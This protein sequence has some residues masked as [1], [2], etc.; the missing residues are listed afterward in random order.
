MV[1]RFSLCLERRRARRAETKT[2][3]HICAPRSSLILLYKKCRL[4]IVK[5]GLLWKKEEV[6]MREGMKL[7]RDLAWKLPLTLCFALCIFFLGVAWAPLGFYVP[8]FSDRRKD[9]GKA[10]AF[11]GT[12]TALCTNVIGVLVCAILVFALMNIVL[13]MVVSRQISLAG[14]DTSITLLQLYS[15]VW[16]RI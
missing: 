2:E 13:T 11:A 8:R 16:L 15:L 14:R 9:S 12:S 5:V 4:C 6:S 10:F 1:R 7:V 3:V